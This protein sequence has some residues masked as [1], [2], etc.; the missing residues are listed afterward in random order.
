MVPYS[1][2]TP[3]V[4]TVWASLSPFPETENRNILTIHLVAM[5]SNKKQAYNWTW[6]AKAL[7]VS[8]SFRVGTHVSQAGLELYVAKDEIYFLSV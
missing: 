6:W 4:A 7:L 1:N 2:P 5:H 3:S 8:F